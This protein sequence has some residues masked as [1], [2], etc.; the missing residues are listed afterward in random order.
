M[1]HK[2]KLWEKIIV[3]RLRGV[4]NVTENQFGFMPGRSTMEAMFLIRQLME[5]CREKERHAYSL[6]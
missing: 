4:A 6:Y 2:M 1:S 5:R 3:H